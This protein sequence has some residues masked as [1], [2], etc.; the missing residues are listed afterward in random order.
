M[1]NSIKILSVVAL[2][3]SASVFAQEQAGVLS[4]KGPKY[5]QQS[6][7]MAQT[8]VKQAGF[9]D[10]DGDGLN[11]NAPDADGDGIPNG[12]DADYTGQKAR[13]GAK[14]KGFVD[15][16]GD[17]INDNALDADGDGIPNGQDEDFVRPQDGSGAMNGKRMGSGQANG[18]GAGTGTGECD[19]TGP[20]GKRNR[21][22]K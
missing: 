21:G 10:E 15:A 4:G 16:D 17:G 22:G 6:K 5:R 18:G 7:S 9:L 1:K 13:R 2:F 3:L 19:E 8:A 12:Q 14:A 20:K 11:D